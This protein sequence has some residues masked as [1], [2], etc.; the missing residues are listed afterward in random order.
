MQGPS[1]P[2]FAE[3][4]APF[5]ESRERTGA[6]AP[7][8]RSGVTAPSQAPSASRRPGRGR[9]E[10]P[11]AG[12]GR[13]PAPSSPA[14]SRFPAS[15]PAARLAHGFAR[16]W[17]AAACALLALALTLG[18]GTA[19]AQMSGIAFSSAT[20]NG[21]TLVMT[22]TEDL[23]T[24]SAPAGSAFSVSAQPSGGSI[25]VILGTGTSAISGRTVTVTLASA[26]AQGETVELFYRIPTTNPLQNK[27][28]FQL[29]GIVRAPVTNNTG[30][31][32]D[33]APGGGVRHE[34]VAGLQQG[35]G[36]GG[37]SREHRL[38]GEEDA[39][40]RRRDGRE[41][42]RVAGDQRRRGD[43]DPGE[44]RGGDRH[45]EGELHQADHGQPATGSCPPA[46]PRRP[47]SR[48][49]R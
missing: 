2:S 4:A 33:A 21:T 8:G 37:E 7:R 32:A 19:E 36:G 30:R 44:R 14:P 15:G 29:P 3:H 42:E 20:V 24:G 17:R 39:V 26:V 46:A 48:T 6:S 43:P 38:R 47:P 18:A 41:P 9:P 40:G 22:V 5:F 49:R 11:P 34:A 25:R 12:D 1:S 27:A 35:A 31:P 10:R 16:G 45:G 28:A 23:D 13:P